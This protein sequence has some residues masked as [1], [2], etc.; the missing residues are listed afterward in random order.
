M[1]QWEACFGQGPGLS[2]PFCQQGFSFEDFPEESG[3]NDGT[4]AH[5]L[6]RMLVPVALTQDFTFCEISI[7]RKEFAVS[8]GSRNLSQYWQ[9]NLD[10]L[11]RT[12]MQHAVI[13]FD[14]FDT[15]ITRPLLNPDAVFDL[16]AIEV[17]RAGG[18]KNFREIRKR[19][20]HEI[21]GKRG[22]DSDVG[23]GEIYQRIRTI[24]KLDESVA[25]RWCRREKEIEILLSIPRTEVVNALQFAKDNH[26]HIILMSDMYLDEA[27]V[28]AL[29]AH[30]GVD[31][32]DE[33][34][35]HPNS[36]Y[37][38]ITAACG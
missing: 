11:K 33:L 18:V 22:F 24:L 15:L 27:T 6:E 21:R 25:E 13:T 38:R 8:F 14:I 16:L 3:Q 1:R 20:E 5:A 10:D 31:G 4:L 34:Y 7:R 36:V 32:Y 35:C 12:I 19:A 2:A 23:I 37:G 29:L 17:E 26:K 28:G 9:K 30:S